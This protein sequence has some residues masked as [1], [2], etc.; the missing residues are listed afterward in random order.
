MPRIF[1][2]SGVAGIR[3]P[4]SRW[5]ALCA[6]I[7]GFARYYYW[8]IHPAPGPIRESGPYTLLLD[9]FYHHQTYLRQPPAPELLALKDPFDPKENERYRLHD[10][11]LYK[12]R[13]YYYFGPAPVLALYLP[14]ALI[15]GEALPDRVGTWLFAT[16]AYLMACLLLKL[17]VSRWWPQSPQ[18]LFFFLC[19][20]LGFSN[21]FPYLLRRPAVYETA[22]AAGQFFVMFAMYAIAR[23]AVDGPHA[24]L[25]AALAGVSLAAAFASRPHL[26]LAAGAL[27]WLLVP[28]DGVPVRDRLRRAALAVFP[29]ALGIGLGLYY[30]FVRFDSPLEFG[31]HYQLEAINVRK[32]QYFSASKIFHDLWLSVLSPPHLRATFPFVA[33]A[34]PPDDYLHKG[35]EVVTGMVWLAPLV[36]LLAGAGVVWRRNDR[37]R[38]LEWSVCAA[39]L[40]VLGAAWIAVDASVGSTMRYQADSAMVLLLASALVITGWS[41]VVGRASKKWLCAVVVALGL[42][43]VAVNGAIGM[44]GYYDNFRFEAPQQYQTTAAIFRPLASVLAWLGVPR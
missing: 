15:T 6:L 14:Y 41:G 22:I 39:T 26:V 1:N 2:T 25:M 24:K 38:R 33:L 19:F 28:G 10:A 4:G 36:L 18:W 13:Y 42:F 7:V 12:D 23:A 5:L 31:N 37:A 17:L 20:C 9:A 43:G 40:A 44:T 29:L 27:V 21:S 8:T 16:A 34:P 3:F 32:I 35:I 11:S 30:N